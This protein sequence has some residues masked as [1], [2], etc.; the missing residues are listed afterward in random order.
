MT[1]PETICQR[2]LAPKSARPFVDA[3]RSP[4]RSGA[5]YSGAAMVRRIRGA[6]ALA[7]VA[8]ACAARATT[9][10]PPQS[11]GST[12][13]VTTTPTDPTTTHVQ[14]GPTGQPHPRAARV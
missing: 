14:P 3:P 9:P 5:R 13:S 8:A 6:V 2:V 7:L 11:T 12:G 10:A 1:R 4:A